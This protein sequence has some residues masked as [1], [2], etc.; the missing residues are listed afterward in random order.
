M[1]Y[2]D[3]DIQH[4]IQHI[5]NITHLVLTGYVNAHSTVVHLYTDDHIGQIKSDVFS[6]WDHITLTTYT[7]TIVSHFNKHLHQISPRSLTRY[8]TG[9]RGQLNKHYHLTTYPS[10]PQLSYVMSTYWNK[11]DEHLLTTKNEWTTISTNLYTDNSIFTNLL[12]P[13]TCQHTNTHTHIH[14]LYTTYSVLINIIQ[15]KQYSTAYLLDSC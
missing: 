10:S 9:H 15:S 8:T 12:N 1:E 5:T 4:C 3:T 6:N 7:Q 11:T 2:T 13:L 14:I